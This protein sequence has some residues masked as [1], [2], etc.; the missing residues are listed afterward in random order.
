MGKNKKK[1]K[2]YKVIARVIFDT[3]LVIR[4]TNKRAAYDLVEGTLPFKK[5]LAGH[6]DDYYDEV[7]DVTVKKE[8]ING[9]I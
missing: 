6:I 7:I 4:A 5:L 8:K 9:K 1:N 2:T 3:E